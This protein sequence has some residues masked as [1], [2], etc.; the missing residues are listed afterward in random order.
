LIALVYLQK[1]R[2]SRDPRQAEKT[3]VKISLSRVRILSRHHGADEKRRTALHV[4]VC[5]E[6]HDWQRARNKSDQ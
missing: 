2:I 3:R 5:P 6:L 4:T 1:V